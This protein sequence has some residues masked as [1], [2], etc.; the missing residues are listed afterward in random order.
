MLAMAYTATHL[1]NRA[2]PST[3]PM[4]GMLSQNANRLF[5]TSSQTRAK[6]R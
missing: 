2:S 4:T 1:E 6:S 5:Q 3:A